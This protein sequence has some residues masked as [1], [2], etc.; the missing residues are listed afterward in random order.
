MVSPE[1][2]ASTAPEPV[3][4]G[5]TGALYKGKTSLKGPAGRGGGGTAVD[6][7]LSKILDD[8]LDELVRSASSQAT[9]P[10]RNRS[11][12]KLAV[13]SPPVTQPQ[14]SRTLPPPTA[15]SP[16]MSSP[17]Q[18]PLED[19]FERS[20]M[21]DSTTTTTPHS[22]TTPLVSNKRVDPALF[23]DDDRRF[24]APIMVVQEEEKAPSPILTPS[25]PKQPPQKPDETNSMAT[26]ATT[27]RTS[28]SSTLLDHRHP[29][30][31][32]IANSIV[33]AAFQCGGAAID[34]TVNQGAELVCGDDEAKSGGGG[35]WCYARW[36]RFVRRHDIARDAK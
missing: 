13:K 29:H 25:A 9:Q 8:S 10:L 7:S 17:P 33:A 21:P 27:S 4:Y 23:K 28:A 1:A 22:T 12:Q 14:R 19:S 6:D 26:S 35:W 5:V 32:S 16:V 3:S 31:A 11:V 24:V 30:N 15:V 36:Q 18:P 2:A 20:V 34:Q